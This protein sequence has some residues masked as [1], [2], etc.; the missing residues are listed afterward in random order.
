MLNALEIGLNKN[1]VNCLTVYCTLRVEW[2]TIMGVLNLNSMT[3]CIQKT[4]QSGDGLSTYI[5]KCIS[6]YVFDVAIK[7]IYFTFSI[8]EWLII[9]FRK[10]YLIII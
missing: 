9:F 5:T 4:I 7:V 10:Y 1:L 8:M 2:V 6:W 3:H